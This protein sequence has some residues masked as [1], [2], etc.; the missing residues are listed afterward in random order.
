MTAQ[1]VESSPPSGLRP[2]AT[3]GLTVAAG[4]AAAVVASF[5]TMG[6]YGALAVMGVGIL[7]YRLRGQLAPVF[8]D[9]V[10]RARDVANDPR[11][12]AARY[13]RDRK[14]VV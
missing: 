3:I 8:E 6:L 14:S 13:P 7:A 12:P 2:L 10:R 1:S 4:V 5:G 11:V 9:A